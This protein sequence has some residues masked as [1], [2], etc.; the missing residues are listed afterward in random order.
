MCGFTNYM[1][2]LSRGQMAQSRKK[3]GQVNAVVRVV[4]HTICIPGHGV[5]FCSPISPALGRLF[6]IPGGRR[7]LLSKAICP[8]SARHSSY[9]ACL[10]KRLSPRVSTEVPC[11]NVFSPSTSP[12]VPFLSVSPVPHGCP[13][14]LSTHGMEH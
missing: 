2:S 1:T 3:V 4:Q 11:L 6:R 7:L 13:S 5:S 12:K 10:P 8:N 9:S 14:F